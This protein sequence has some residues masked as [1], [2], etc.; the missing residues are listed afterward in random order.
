MFVTYPRVYPFDTR[1]RPHPSGFEPAHRTRASPRDIASLRGV[2]LRGVLLRA[3]CSLRVT[4]QGNPS[5]VPVPQKSHA[6]PS[7]VLQDFKLQPRNCNVFK[8]NQKLTKLNYLRD[9]WGTLDVGATPERHQRDVREESDLRERLIQV[10]DQ[11]AC[12]LQ[13]DREAQERAGHPTHAA[14]ARRVGHDRRVLDEGLG[15]AQ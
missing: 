10:R 13:A 9:L 1:R 7:P 3:R 15:R 8:H 14:D 6:I 2:L 4:A 12:I 11:I 5:L